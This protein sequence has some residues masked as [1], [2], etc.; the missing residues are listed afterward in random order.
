MKFDYKIVLTNCCFVVFYLFFNV[1]LQAEIKTGNST[2]ELLSMNINLPATLTTGKKTIVYFSYKNDSNVEVYVL[3][4]GDGIQSSSGVSAI[5][6]GDEGTDS[7]NFL[8]DDP[9]TI[10][11]LVLKMIA[12]SSP[13]VVIS[14]VTIPGTVSYCTEV[15]QSQCKED[16]PPSGAEP[17]TGHTSGVYSVAFSPDGQ[18]AL[19]GSMDSILKL[20]DVNSGAEI[21]SFREHTY[22]VWSVAFSPDGRYA[23]SGSSDETLKLWDVSTGKKIRTFHGHT[24][25]V[26]SVAFSPDGQYALSG[27]GDH[28]LKLWDVS[29]GAEIRTFH[30]HT[31]KIESVAFSPDG[32]YALSGSHDSTLKLW[33]VNSGAEIRT[34]GGN[35]I[36]WVYA[37]AFS[38]NGQYVLSGNM[39]NT[40]KLWDVN[41]GIEIRTFRGHTHYIYSVA[42]SPDGRYA[43][44][45]SWDSTLKLW[46]V[47]NGAE[48][49]TFSGHTDEVH[50]VAF[51]PDG[52]YA[53]SG[54]EDLTLKLWETGLGTTTNLVNISTRAPIQ[55]GAN[56]V[57]AGFIITGT[58]TLK[59]IIR[60]WELGAGVDP[61]LLLQ[62]Y[63]EG[64]T[65][66][67]NNNWENGQRANEIKALPTNLRLTN[68]TDAGLLLDLPA[69]AYTATLS[70]IGSK[71]RGLIGV[72]EVETSNTAKLT[73]ISTRAPI[74]GDA[75]DVIAGFII[76]GGI[77][78]GIKKVM[79]RGFALGNGV[80]PKLTLQKYPSNE[81]VASNDNWRTDVRASEIPE[82]LKLPNLTDA[83]LLL[84]LPAGA[85]TVRLSSV[86]A[87]G[88]GLIG[89]NA[90][91]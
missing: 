63:P 15:V 68:P 90:L 23:L 46:D 83:G 1:A 16:I 36:N 34:F 66:A 33:D 19:S 78:A 28:T 2:I 52:R 82:H 74:Q 17:F 3:V 37:V 24:V 21:R 41:S 91:D 39:D 40:V 29:S 35:T 62:T 60:G 27:S 4:E 51:S 87:K 26:N 13:N 80:N 48:I 57:I 65:I 71:G 88:L 14:K 22:S 53:L 47:N 25:Y 67:G 50:T 56:D 72:N 11:N 86:G 59:V 54:S 18:Y 31:A 61:N 45:G 85:Y 73:N 43:L 70:S 8:R 42:F 49:R 69:G 12:V 55:G 79:I 38:P 64:K 20:W 44:S 77:S 7:Y 81:L 5:Q 9:G 10:S 58:G 89:V 30:G 32:K 76:T 84:Y 75:D 6:P